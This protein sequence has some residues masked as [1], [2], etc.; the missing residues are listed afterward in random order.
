M[1]IFDKNTVGD[2]PEQFKK[3]SD[4]HAELVRQTN[5]IGKTGDKAAF[6]AAAERAFAANE[7]MMAIWHEMQKHRL[8]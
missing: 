8:D 1:P 4:E 7:R 2:L 5:E 6:Y 3:A